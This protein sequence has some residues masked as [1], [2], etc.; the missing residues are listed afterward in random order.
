MGQPSRTRHDLA[1]GAVFINFCN[2]IEKTATRAVCFSKANESEQQCRGFCSN[3]F[4]S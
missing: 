2:D 3:S 4:G 1:G